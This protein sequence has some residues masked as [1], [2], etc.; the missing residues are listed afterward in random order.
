MIDGFKGA[1]LGDIDDRRGGELC[2]VWN[3]GE[4]VGSS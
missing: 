2:G 4:G 3:L 1:W